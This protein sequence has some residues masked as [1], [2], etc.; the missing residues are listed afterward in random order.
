MRLVKLLLVGIGLLLVVSCST[1]TPEPTPTPLPTL[2]PTPAIPA[3]HTAP[4]TVKPVQPE[5]THAPQLAHV[6]IIS[7]EGLRP[8]ALDATDPPDLDALR[9]AG[10]YSPGARAV[11]PS[12]TLVNHAS[13]LG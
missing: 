5:P 11:L 8:D 2:T 1:S 4:P 9:A 12:V 13:M 10:A 7:L 3:T 6:V